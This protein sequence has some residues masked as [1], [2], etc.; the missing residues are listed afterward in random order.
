MQVI[1]NVELAEELAGEAEEEGRRRR[2]E[3]REAARLV[4]QAAQAMDVAS[5]VTARALEV[6]NCSCRL[7]RSSD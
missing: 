6:R 2:G 7:S 3:V 4:D 5:T 1:Q